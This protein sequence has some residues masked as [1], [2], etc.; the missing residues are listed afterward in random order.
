MPR[1]IGAGVSDPVDDDAALLGGFLTDTVLRH[2]GDQ[3]GSLLGRVRALSGGA[4]SEAVQLAELL[5]GLDI[6]AATMLVRSL[7]VDLHLTTTAEQVHRAD[8][9]AERARTFRG[10]LR[11]TV[12][13]LIADGVDRG[14]VES[15][16]ARTEVRLVFTAHP[17]EAKR[18]SVLRQRHR[19]AEL[20]EARRDP[21]S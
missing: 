10:S 16:L 13:D 1:P 18:R 19:I 21:R 7:A 15:L 14:E 5:E 12:A 8:E 2:E 20:L 17:T 3:V 4:H 6:T 9:L 11:H